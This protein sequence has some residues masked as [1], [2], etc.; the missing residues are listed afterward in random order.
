[1]AIQ[2]DLELLD[3]VATPSGFY[4]SFDLNLSNVSCYIALY[5]R[6][7]CVRMRRYICLKFLIIQNQDR[8]YLHE[9]KKFGLI[10]LS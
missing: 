7:Y 4:D 3:D 2:D 6:S 9:V 5:F 8:A 1:M 10:C